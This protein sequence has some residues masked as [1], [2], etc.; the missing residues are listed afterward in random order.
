MAELDNVSRIGD[1]NEALTFGN[2]KGLDQH[3]EL[4][5]ELVQKD[6]KHGY[7]LV[8]PPILAPM[9]IATQNSIDD[10]G[11][12][13]PKDRLTQDQSWKWKVGASVNIRVDKDALIP[14]QFGYALRRMINWTAAARHQFPGH[15]IYATKVDY[16]S[17][18]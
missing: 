17:V 6:I 2:H 11:R 16:K 10:C 4:L 5:K 1:L 14:C 3:P 18:Y 13:V 7:G 15:R 8:I 12:I 9:N